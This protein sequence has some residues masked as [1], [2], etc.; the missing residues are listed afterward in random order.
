M[1][2]RSPQCQW[3]WLSGSLSTSLI[4]LGNREEPASHTHTH[5]L[6]KTCQLWFSVI[7]PIH[8]GIERSLV[9]NGKGSKQ[10]WHIAVDTPAQ[11]KKHIKDRLAQWRM[12]SRTH[13]GNYKVHMGWKTH[14]DTHSTVRGIWADSWECHACTLDRRSNKGEDT[15]RA[16]T[17]ISCA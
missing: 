17:L 11:P 7:P 12:N 4:N 5:T 6:S 15:A 3:W 1:M 9:H 2:R 16:N 14:S 8:R 13:T 10:I